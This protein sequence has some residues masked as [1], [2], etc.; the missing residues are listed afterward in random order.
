[1]LNQRAETA[2]TAFSRLVEVGRVS[3]SEFDAK[4]VR[5]GGKVSA[6]TIRIVRSYAH[7]RI[8][9]LESTAG[10]RAPPGMHAKGANRG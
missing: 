1:M 3:I 7:D 2:D 6:K 4:M 9:H 10:A 5:I 8:G